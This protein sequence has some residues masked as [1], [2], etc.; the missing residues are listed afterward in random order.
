MLVKNVYKIFMIVFILFA[1]SIQSQSIKQL[2]KQGTEAITN[3]D[4]SSAA[5]IYNQ[6][7]LLDSSKIEYQL[8]FADAS[9]LNFDN[10]IALHW[11]QKYTNK[12]M[13]RH[14]KKCLFIL[15]HF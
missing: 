11:F 4:Y 3:K 10:E 8:L 15:L 1:N 7:I 6:I 5:Q 2:L 14:I 12:I 13:V 9:R